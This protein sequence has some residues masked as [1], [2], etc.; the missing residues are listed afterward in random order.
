MVKKTFVLLI[1]LFCVGIVSYLSIPT[2]TSSV[3]SGSRCWNCQAT[4][5]ST[6]AA[7][8]DS[9]H[10]GSPPHETI[11]FTPVCYWTCPGG[12][13]SCNDVCTMKVFK[14][15]PGGSPNPIVIFDPAGSPHYCDG[16]SHLFNTSYTVTSPNTAGYY[17]AELWFDGA[18][19]AECDLIYWAGP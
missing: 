9:A 5:D 1:V 12:G 8:V 3:E 16:N 19:I 6:P 17:W 11:T 14:S 10:T 2:A 13:G 15:N 18:K 7:S 4:I